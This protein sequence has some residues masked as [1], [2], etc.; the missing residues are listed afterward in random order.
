MKKNILVSQIEFFEKFGQMLNSGVPILKALE[1]LSREV[2]EK[3]IKKEILFLIENLEKIERNEAKLYQYFNKKIFKEST[4][5]M[6][7]SGEEK[8]ELDYICIKIANCLRAE[9]LGTR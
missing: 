8:G 1:I 3:S 7:E 5:A 2:S 4:I 6:I 9:L